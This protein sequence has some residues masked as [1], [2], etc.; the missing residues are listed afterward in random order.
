MRLGYQFGAR[1]RSVYRGFPDTVEHVVALAATDVAVLL[2]REAMRPHHWEA[3]VEELGEILQ[4][5]KSVDRYHRSALKRLSAGGRFNDAWAACQVL[6][7]KTTAVGG[8]TW[9]ELLCGFHDVR[10]EPDIPGGWACPALSTPE[11]EMALSHLGVQGDLAGSIFSFV[12]D[13]N[14]S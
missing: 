8:L 12:R 5:R 11:I 1:T 13:L 10:S 3:R 2:V 9:W 4:R 14:V 6:T 7:T